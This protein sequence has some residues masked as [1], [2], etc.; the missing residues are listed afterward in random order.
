VV[1]YKSL[2]AFQGRF[3]VAALVQELPASHL[4][5]GEDVENLVSKVERGVMKR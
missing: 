3:L 1:E 2:L 5:I 4:F